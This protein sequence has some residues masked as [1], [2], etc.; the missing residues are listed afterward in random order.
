M[1]DVHPIAEQGYGQGAGT[2][3]F[4]KLLAQTG[5]DVTAVEPV[6]AMLKELRQQLPGVRTIQGTAQHIP[7]PDSSVDAVV[8]AQSFHWFASAESL[9][10]FRRVLKPGGALGL[11]WNVRD[12]SVEWVGKLACILATHEGDAPRYDHGEWRHVFPAR[13]F[14]EL[15]ER[16]IPHVHTGSPERVIV[17][18]VASVSFIAALDDRTRGEVLAEVRALISST[19][20]LA[21]H[22]QVGFPYLTSIYWC[23]RSDTLAT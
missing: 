8:C 5:A 4:T 13:G 18:R 6:A 17:D 22:V 3:K 9:A 2:G 20:E 16:T 11:I 23:R 14:C 1:T 10:E 12:A 21:N 7:L 15:R 19:P